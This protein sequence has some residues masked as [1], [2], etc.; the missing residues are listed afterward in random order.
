MKNITIQK[1]ATIKADGKRE[2][3]NCKAV[4]CIETGEV[5]SSGADAAESIGVHFSAISAA[6]LGKSKTCNGKHYCYLSAALENLDAV[7]A[8]LRQAAQMEGD[9]N[10]W[11]A[12]ENAKEEERMARERYAADVA[13]A[14]SKVAKLAEA[15]AKYQEKLNATMNEY[16]EAC[17]ELEALLNKGD[18]DCAKI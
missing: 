7:M 8:R 5:F 16:D 6:C 17:K 1:E 14:E 3:G 13:R 11:R 15:C 4:L 9:A 10:K 18:G 2:R 12:Q